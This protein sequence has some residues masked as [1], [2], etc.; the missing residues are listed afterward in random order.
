MRRVA[1][2]AGFVCL[3]GSVL[4]NEWAHGVRV[5]L[6]ADGELSSRGADLVTCLCSMRIMTVAALHEPDIDSVTVR[7]RELSLLARVTAEAEVRLRFH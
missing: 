4:E 2:H 3:Y 1:R 7:T 6:R 5:A